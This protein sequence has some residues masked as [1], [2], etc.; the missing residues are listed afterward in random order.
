VRLSCTDWVPGGWDLEQSVELSRRLKAEGVDLMDCSSGGN[1]PDAKI[2]AGPGYQVPFA[3]RIRREAG[4]MTAAVGSITA[5]AQADQIVR[6]GSADLVLL[7]REFLR[8]PNWPLRAARALG[9]PT[10][11]QPP[12]QYARA[13]M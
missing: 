8:D 13:W 7:A 11:I 3:E 12:V 10:A 5:P 6:N 2:P 1:V 4:V 9:Q